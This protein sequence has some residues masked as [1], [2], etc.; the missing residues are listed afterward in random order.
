MISID[1]LIRDPSF[2]TNQIGVRFA[3]KIVNFLKS[4]GVKP[5]DLVANNPSAVELNVEYTE[6]LRAIEQMATTLAI[7]SSTPVKGVYAKRASATKTTAKIPVTAGGTGVVN[8][9]WIDEVRDNCVT[10]SDTS[11]RT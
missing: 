3:E 1:E 8:G 9:K 11:Y 7:D 4:C 5:S 2:Q 6:I 10:L